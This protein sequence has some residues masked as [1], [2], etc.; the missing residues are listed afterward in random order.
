MPSPR[1]HHGSAHD[2]FISYT[3]ADNQ[4]DRIGAWVERFQSDEGGGV[5]FFHVEE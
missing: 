1:F 3:H 2:V 4:P 5:S